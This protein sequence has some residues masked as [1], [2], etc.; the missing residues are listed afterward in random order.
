MNIQY[1]AEKADRIL[2]HLSLLS[3]VRLSLLDTQYRTVTSS[4]IVN[5]FCKKLQENPAARQE[6]YYCDRSIL[7]LC[8][9]SGQLETHICHAGLYDFAMPLKKDGI[10]AGFLIFGQIRSD[11]S[12]STCPIHG[13]AAQYRKT[14]F[15]NR[16]KIDCLRNLLPLILFDD[17]ITINYDCYFDSVVQY[18][19]SHVHEPLCVD[20]LCRKFH[21]SKNYLYKSFHDRFDST[22]ND[23]ITMTRLQQA[24]KYLA[25]TDWAIY[26]IAEKVGIANYTYF[27]RVFK[28]KTGLTPNA[29]RQQ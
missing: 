5:P 11:R 28:K 2:N 7:D 19:K 17:V 16:E 29:Y 13:L 4:K 21:V 6:C 8:K 23:F 26:E 22:V 24:K 27:C 3:G 25:E 12:P 14:P 10:L 20:F 9:Q 18:I 1:H 15:Y